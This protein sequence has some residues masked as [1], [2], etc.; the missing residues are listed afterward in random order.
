MTAA[1]PPS[2]RS[3]GERAGVRG[4]AGVDFDVWSIGV[5]RGPSPFALRPEARPILTVADVK[6]VDA[7]FLA[8]PFMLRADGAWHMFFEVLNLNGRIG[9]IGRA[10]SRDGITWQ[11]GGIVLRE[12]FHLSYPCVFESG[13]EHWMIPETLGAK[14]IRLYRADPFPHRWT[15][16]QDLIPIAAADPTPFFFGNRWWMFVCLTPY[17]HRTLGLYH[18]PELTGPWT[19]HATH[20]LIPDDARIGRPGGRVL[21]TGGRLFR[22]AQDCT[23]RY[24]RQVRALEIVSLTPDTYRERELDVSPILGPSG[25]GWNAEGMHHIDAHR[26]EDGSWMACVDGRRL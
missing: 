4:D 7:V 5:L 6:D 1:V 3:G 26:L 21:S 24:G 20:P 12:P 25:A 9:E 2:P 10:I 18:A 14:A 11:Y 16:V 17:Q 15:L 19:P 23:P 22:F 13:G 8:D